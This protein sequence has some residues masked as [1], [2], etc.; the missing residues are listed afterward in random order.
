MRKKT[1]LYFTFSL[2]SILSYG[3]EIFTTTNVE[4]LVAIEYE[5]FPDASGFKMKNKSIA[6]DFTSL[7][8]KPTFGFGLNYTNNSIDF[9]GPDL[10][11][12]FRSFREIHTI[13][14]YMNYN[15]A[16]ANNWKVSLEIA[17]YLSSTFNKKVTSEDFLL[18]SAAHFIKN[19]QKD[20]KESYLKIGAGYGALFGAPN[21]YPLVTY[22]NQVSEKFRYQIGIPVTG[23][24]YTINKQSSI[25]FTAQPESIYANNA[26]PLFLEDTTAV[27]DS[28]LEFQAIKLA[29]GYQ[30][31][32]DKNWTTS[33][34]VGYL[35]NS[36]LTINNNSNNEIYNFDSSESLSVSVGLSFNINKK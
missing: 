21:F 7:L 35:T 28:K 22:S 10:Q 11:S 5:Y 27:Y 13:Q 3:Q 33:F 24:Y 14:M 17:P 2:V 23:A 31:R 30:L 9:K 20:G 36:T 16:L 26:A 25:D 18:S 8:K 4:D 32:F 1:L 6:I 19:W 34:N 15:K 12:A 29:L